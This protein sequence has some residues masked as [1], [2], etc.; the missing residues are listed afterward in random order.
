M[1][2]VLPLLACSLI[3]Y[4]SIKRIN[5]YEAF[6]K[7][8]LEALPMLLKILPY[9]A[10]MLICIKLLVDG[11]V[12][13]AFIGLIRGPLNALGMPEALLPLALLRQFSGSGA[14][15]LVTEIF[16]KHGTDS[17]LGLMASTMMGA[18]ETIF[19]T[20]ALYFGSAGIKKTGFTLPVS[21]LAALIS[22]V[23]SV[24][25]VNWLF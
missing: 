23:M 17:S 12:L 1:S 6:V 16:E 9:I 8:A 18:S 14:M 21:L 4:A 3:I 2:A 11:G 22:I 20:L 10:A 19:Y 25:A 15:A 5:V 13:Y 7:G 24:L